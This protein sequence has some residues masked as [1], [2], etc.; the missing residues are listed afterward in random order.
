MGTPAHGFRPDQLHDRN[1]ADFQTARDALARVKRDAMVSD[2]VWMK[3]F[4]A[5]MAAAGQAIDAKYAALAGAPGAA[6]DVLEVGEGNGFGFY[7]VYQNGAVYWR[8]DIGAF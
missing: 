1:I 7:R 6:Q 3:E 8:R 2:S 5:E 4:M